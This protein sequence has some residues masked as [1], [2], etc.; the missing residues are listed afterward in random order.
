MTWAHSTV[1]NQWVC[2]AC[3]YMRPGAQPTAEHD[4]SAA[5]EP[6]PQSVRAA[7]DADAIGARIRELRAQRG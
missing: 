4:C 7:D 5:A 6:V 3:Q 2:Q 1:E